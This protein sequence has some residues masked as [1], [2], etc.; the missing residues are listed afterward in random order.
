MAEARRR[1]TVMALSH[2]DD[3]TR[4]D[5]FPHEVVDRIRIGY[6]SQLARI[7]RRLEP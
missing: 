7:D 6:E 4:A 5:R 3:L 2:I 1:L